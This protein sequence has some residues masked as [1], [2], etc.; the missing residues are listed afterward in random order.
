MKRIGFIGGGKMAGAI[1]GSLLK[2]GYDAAGLTVSDCSEEAR[3]RHA[4]SGVYVTE[5]NAE[6]C[7]RSD[8]VFL[9]VKPQ[10]MAVALA[11]IGAAADGK[12]LVTMAAGIKTE[13]VRACCPGAACVI[14]MMPN[15]PMLVNMGTIAVAFNGAPE[16]AAA[17]VTAILSKAGE[18]FAV[19]E[20]L[21]DAVTALSGS[22]P[23]YFY[24]F[25]QVLAAA[26]AAQGLPYETAVKMAAKTM[27]GAAEMLLSTGKSPE[28][29]LRDVSSAKGTTVAALEAFDAAG[30]DA[31]LKSGVDAAYRRSVELAAGK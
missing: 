17:D 4:A 12:T 30:L 3:A 25:A 15:T 1:L 26:A 14:R 8:V 5:D 22:G 19:E 23:A 11:G 10:Q 18:V 27:A 16:G 28:E 24:R 7:S 2:N 20:E 6:A 31:A 9:A 13:T 29:L 21:M